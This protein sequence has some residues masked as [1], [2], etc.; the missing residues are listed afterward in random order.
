MD[1]RGGRG[2][3]I[4]WASVRRW[5]AV[6]AWLVGVAFVSQ[7]AA[8]QPTTRTR[9]PS[10]TARVE[11]AD[12]LLEG[13]RAENIRSEET[14]DRM[15]LEDGQI[16]VDLGSGP[17]LFT[18]PLAARIAPH[19]IVLAVDIQQ[20]MLDRLKERMM[21]ADVRNV[22]P[23]LSVSDDPLLPH[24]KVDWMLLVDVYHEISEPEA[25]LARMK[26]S[27]APGGRI[28]LYEI[29]L[30]AARPRSGDQSMWRQHYTLTR[31][32]GQLPRNEDRVGAHQMTIEQVMTEWTAAGFEL[33]ERAEYVPGQHVFVFKVAGDEVAGTWRSKPDLERRQVGGTAATVFDDNVFLAGQPGEA[34]LQ[35]FAELGVDTVVSLRTAD[36]MATLGFDE[37]AVVEGAGMTYLHVPIDGR[38]PEE[39]SILDPVMDGILLARGEEQ[40]LVH[41]EDGN[42]AG[43]I[44]ALFRAVGQGLPVDESIEEGQAVGLRDAGMERAIRMYADRWHVDNDQR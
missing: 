44:W 42:R 13:A 8:Q 28:L 36:G 2:S 11:G 24:G 40:V 41:D 25:M 16:V 21:E 18:L 17:G 19:G 33:E 4:G 30:E 20:G 27:L 31:S 26:E 32:G 23:I 34:D 1:T 14:L 12:R 35:A 29:A 39:I 6:T 15:G 22:L 3:L 10:S 38:L 37:R 9:Q 43:A 7:L 5:A